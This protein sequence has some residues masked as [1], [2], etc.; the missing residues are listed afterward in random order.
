MIDLKNK[1]SFIEIFPFKHF[2][3]DAYILADICIP[4]PSHVCEEQA[5][6]AR[7]F[8]PRGPRRYQAVHRAVDTANG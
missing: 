8:V 7:R 5:A 2:K 3:Q 1:K 6:L 4:G